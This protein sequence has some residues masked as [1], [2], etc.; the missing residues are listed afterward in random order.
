MNRVD[1][2][3]HIS[4]LYVLYTGIVNSC[5]W[6]LIWIFKT[7]AVG[8][9]MVPGGHVNLPRRWM[10]LFSPGRCSRSETC[11]IGGDRMTLRQR[12]MLFVAINDKPWRARNRPTWMQAGISRYFDHSGAIK[13]LHR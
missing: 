6:L 2:G 12:T 4:S 7:V 1:I 10:S 8:R 5:F 3:Q 11:T 13:V 9:P